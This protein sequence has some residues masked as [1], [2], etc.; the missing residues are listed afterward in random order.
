MPIAL[1]S[2]AHDF[3][4]ACQEARVD[5]EL[6]LVPTMGSLHAGH[7][8]LIREAALRAPTVA[9]T[10]FVNP[11]Q[12]GPR[13]DLSKYPRDLQ[14]DLRKC[15]E[16]GATFVFAPDSTEIYPPGFQTWVEPGPLAA[17][18]EGAR[19]PG[20]F[21][22]V[23][24]AVAKL[25]ALSR[26]DAAFF[27]EK[28]YQQ[29]LVVRRMA[30]DLSFGTEVIGRP[31]VREPDGLAMSSRNVYLT[32]QQRKRATALWKALQ[33]VRAKFAA[34]ERD[35]AALESLARRIIEEAGLRV[36]Y[37]EIRDPIE[38][39]RPARAEASSRLFLAAFMGD[40]RLIDNG[41]LA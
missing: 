30:F 9:A 15:E 18:L 41:E 26:A 10:I 4:R 38:L 39:Q 6:A 3:R 37:A 29:L 31:I 23:C 21:R 27:G 40:T 16:A 36:D 32:P 25:F 33:A 13:E 14:S 5:G 19:R 12:F 20:H 7:Q 2:A 24:T 22:G 17:P 34:G 11:A 1:V 35:V 28:D 8:S